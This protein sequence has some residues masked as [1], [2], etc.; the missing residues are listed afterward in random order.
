M[1]KQ[2]KLYYHKSYIF[3]IYPLTAELL[4]NGTTHL[5]I[6]KNFLHLPFHC[7]VI[8]IDYG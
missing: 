4:Q 6:L 7:R 5:P 1:R 2:T 8:D 3:M